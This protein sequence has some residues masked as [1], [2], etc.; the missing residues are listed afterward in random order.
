MAV[1][2]GVARL[3][4]ALARVLKLPALAKPTLAITRMILMHHEPRV[5]MS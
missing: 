1:L 3:G 4:M 5:F 2:M